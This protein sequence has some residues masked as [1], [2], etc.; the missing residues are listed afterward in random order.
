VSVSFNA[1]QKA[2]PDGEGFLRELWGLIKNAIL[3]YEL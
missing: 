2:F 3:S 1:E